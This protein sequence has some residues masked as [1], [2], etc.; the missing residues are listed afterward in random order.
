MAKN[1]NSWSDEQLK[2]IYNTCVD[3][4]DNE[5]WNYIAEKLNKQLGEDCD[6][7]TYRKMFN[8]FQMIFRAIC[9]DLYDTEYLKHLQEKE[10]RLYKQQI[11]T[12]DMLREYRKVL[13]DESRIETLKECIKSRADELEQL[14]LPE[15][16]VN[17][18]GDNFVEAFLSISD[19]HIGDEFKSFMNEFNLEIAKEKISRLSKSVNDYCRLYQVNRLNV[20]N[21]GDLIEGVI[22]VTGR[23]ESEFDVI[24]QIKMASE[25]LSQFLV[26]LVGCANEITL[27]YTLDNHARVVANYKEHIEKENFGELIMWYLEARL[28]DTPIQV[29][30]DNLDKNIG[31]FKSYSGKNIFFAH[32]HLEKIDSVLETM[33]FGSGII[34]D[35]VFLGHYH[36]ALSKEKYSRKIYINGSLKGVDNYA[37]KNRLFARP[38]QELLILNG[39]DEIDC[40]I[41]LD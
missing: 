17:H 4:K 23:I 21:L 10:E 16:E 8:G 38:S 27:R 2:I 19:W 3:K 34:A 29:I 18:S 26:S 22:H 11:R 25:L 13:R 28:K 30:N 39:N 20:L 31:Y 35:Y 36:Q 40:R 14:S 33:T 12:Q 5:S 24:N 1:I 32:G 6:E 7:S 15:I 41:N 9:D 37:L